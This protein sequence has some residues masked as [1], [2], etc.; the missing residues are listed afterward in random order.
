MDKFNSDNNEVEF[1]LK[2]ASEQLGEEL[3]G[4]SLGEEP[5]APPVEEVP[6]EPSAPSAPSEEEPSE[7]DPLP[8]ASTPPPDTWKK[9][10]KEQWATLSPEIQTEV[11]R[12]EQEIFQGL[13]QY[14]AD[15]SI[16]NYLKQIVAPHQE[17]FTNSGENPVKLLNDLTQ[18]HVILSTADPARRRE[19]FLTVAKSYGVDLLSESAYIDPQVQSLQKELQGVKSQ[20][21][22]RAQQEATAER[23]KLQLEIQTFFNDPANTYVN[24][25]ADDMARLLRSGMATNPKD[26]YEQAVRLNPTVYA[27]ELSRVREEEAQRIKAESESKLDKARKASAANVRS[28]VK[29]ASAA[30]PVGTMDD[31]LLEQLATIKARS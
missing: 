8:P 3:F 18:A 16:G 19:L 7:K 30:T 29:S 22:S 21:H 27:K 28:K 25:V 23:Q 2:A 1:D 5:P 13:E 6:A 14:K 11:L 10:A 9:E 26:A 31:T 20:L 15:A 17:F 12:R 4:A 24:E